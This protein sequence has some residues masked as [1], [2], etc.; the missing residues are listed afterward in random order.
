MHR[1]A[2]GYLV[3][4]YCI[5]FSANLGFVYL[6]FRTFLFYEQPNNIQKDTH[7]FLSTSDTFVKGY[8][9]TSRVFSDAFDSVM[10]G[11]VSWNCSIQS[12]K[13]HI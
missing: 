12:K 8:P 10:Y 13:H 4:D 1:H 3:S 7:T 2:Q 5:Y 6:H 11:S 9:L